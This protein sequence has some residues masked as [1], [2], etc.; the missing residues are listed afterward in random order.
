MTNKIKSFQY[1]PANKK[2]FLLAQNNVRSALAK[3]LDINLSS[4]RKNKLRDITATILGFENG[5]QQLKNQLSETID[6]FLDIMH[7]AIKLNAEA[8]HLSLN[9]DFLD[10]NLKLKEGN[11]VRERLL[12][13][14]YSLD[15]I[16][17]IKIK[18][19][20]FKSRYSFTLGKIEY[21]VSPIVSKPS[22]N[23]VLSLSL[24]LKSTE[25]KD[26]LN[27]QNDAEYI[28][29]AI[30][31]YESGIFLFSGVA[32]S[33]RSI[34]LL[35]V[36]QKL[37]KKHGT[38]LSTRRITN[39]YDNSNL[40]DEEL[41]SI[42]MRTNPEIVCIGEIRDSVSAKA[43]IRASEKGAIVLG[44]IHASGILG[45][46]EQMTIKAQQDISMHIKGGIHQMLFRRK[47]QNCL[48]TGCIKCMETGTHGREPVIEKAFLN[49]KTGKINLDPSLGHQTILDVATEKY[50]LG[51]FNKEEMIRKLG[52]QVFR[53]IKF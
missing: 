28:S 45:A 5:Y 9:N 20:N 43:A 35:K 10:I 48:G 42:L 4:K 3:H 53:K 36:M 37:S 32:A 47:C 49:L 33:G 30:L 50:K 24:R 6:P 8:I 40:T 41:F 26:Y 11:A 15:F 34:T 22:E 2:E 27:L 38:E 18:T 23:E 52:E 12:E 39:E 13:A 7:T 25:N 29:E 19:Q 1:I 21:L 14:P 17:S 31:Q 51:L 16:E 44:T 46:M